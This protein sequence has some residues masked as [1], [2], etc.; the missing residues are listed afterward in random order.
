M[1]TVLFRADASSTIG[2][3]H[4]MRD[5][6]LAKQYSSKNN[7]ELDIV[8]NKLDIDL[9]VINHYNIHDENEKRLK[10]KNPQ[11]KTL[12]NVLLE[13]DIHKIPSLLQRFTNA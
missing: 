2:T 6:V 1:K 8:V 12:S 9:L 11:L 3:G 5:L 13:N 4:I 7:K 10:T